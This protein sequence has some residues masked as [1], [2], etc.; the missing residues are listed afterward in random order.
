MGKSSD[1]RASARLVDAM[2]AHAQLTD[3]VASDDL[4]LLPLDQVRERRN[5]MPSQPSF[6]LSP[7]TTDHLGRS[8]RSGRLYHDV[9]QYVDVEQ[10]T[11]DGSA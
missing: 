11:H 10:Q 6:V 5:R 8:L 9:Q 1:D 7:A 3:E 2:A 4:R